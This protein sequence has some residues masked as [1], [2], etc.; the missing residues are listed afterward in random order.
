VNE[1]LLLI[2]NQ[3][4]EAEIPVVRDKKKIEIR[5][6]VPELDVPLADVSF[7]F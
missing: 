1:F 6:K 2:K 4:K 3:G 5:V 7:L